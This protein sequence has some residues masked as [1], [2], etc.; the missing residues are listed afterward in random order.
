MKLATRSLLVAL[1]GALT[2]GAASSALAHGDR[3]WKRGHGHYK[4]GWYRGNVVVVG[5]PRYIYREPVVVYPRPA[6]VVPEPV[7]VYPSRPALTIGLSIPPL[8]IPF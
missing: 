6:V 3:Y 1:L 8:V 2:L 5:A 4:H 7:Y